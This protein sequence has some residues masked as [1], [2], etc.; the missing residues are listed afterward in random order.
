MRGDRLDALMLPDVGMTP[1]SRFP[2]STA[3]PRWQFTAWGHPV[4]SGSA[5]MDDY[6]SSDLMEP[7]DAQDHYTEKLVRLRNLRTLPRPAGCG[8]M[9]AAE[10]EFGLPE[11]RIRYG[12]PGSAPL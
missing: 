9:A 10:K 7:A 2:R 4:T 3:L 12:L 6:L 8:R 1:L 11:G 5:Q